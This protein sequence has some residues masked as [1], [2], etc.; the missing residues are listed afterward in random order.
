MT[1][2]NSYESTI[3]T[4]PL[5]VSAQ[6]AADAGTLEAGDVAH[7]EPDY[8]P[9][10]DRAVPDRVLWGNTHLY[11][12]YSADADFFL[13]NACVKNEDCIAA[14]WFIERVFGF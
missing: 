11:T 2:E 13:I 4:V 3:E 10:G 1:K 8:S 14:F 7:D 5:A 9:F 12:S 6:H